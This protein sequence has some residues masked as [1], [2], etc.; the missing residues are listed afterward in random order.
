ML[1]IQALPPPFW[2]KEI[3]P[4]NKILKIAVMLTA[5]MSVLSLSAFAGAA[6]PPTSVPEPATLVLLATGMGAVAVVRKFRSK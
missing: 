4:M 6:V 3:L 2:K 1:S 5:A